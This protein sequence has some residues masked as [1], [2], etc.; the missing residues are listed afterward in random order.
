[1]FLHKILQSDSFE[2]VGF[3]YDKNI[4]KFKSKNTQIRHFWSGSG[5]GFLNIPDNIIQESKNQILFGDA[6]N[7]KNFN[8]NDMKLCKKLGGN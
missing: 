1:M 4:F 5:S 3:N 2:D 6:I 7:K 8:D